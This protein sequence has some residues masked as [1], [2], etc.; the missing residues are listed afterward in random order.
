MSGKPVTL[1]SRTDLFSPD[2]LMNRIAE[3]KL[4]RVTLTP[5]CFE[6]LMNYVSKNPR[7]KD[8]LA[9]VTHWFVSGGRLKVEAGRKFFS[10]FSGVYKSGVFLVAFYGMTETLGEAT[11]EVFFN[12]EDL[13]K[14]VAPGLG[15]LSMG[16]PISK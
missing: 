3:V 7:D 4:T 9:S 12:V 16:V 2:L 8:K 14:K 6:A 10:N 1:L 15:T 13:N 11:F 5:P